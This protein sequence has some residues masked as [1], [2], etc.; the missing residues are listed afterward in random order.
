MKNL[1]S[2]APPSGWW[3]PALLCPIQHFTFYQGG[4]SFVPSYPSLPFTSSFP[5]TQIPWLYS[6]CSGPRYNRKP[7]SLQKGQY[8]RDASQKMPHRIPGNN[9]W[10]FSLT[11]RNICL[12]WTLPGSGRW[13]TTGHCKRLP[14]EITSSLPHLQ[15]KKSTTHGITSSCVA[16][17]LN[18]RVLPRQTVPG[19]LSISQQPPTRERDTIKLIRRVWNSSSTGQSCGSSKKSGPVTSGRKW[20][21]R[22]GGQHDSGGDGRARRGRRHLRR[23]LIDTCIRR[24]EDIVLPLK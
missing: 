18:Y 12:P 15:W 14:S 7:T 3:Y 23:P 22:V 1:H 19:K 24:L 16:Q 20:K 13:N 8:N 6:R 9:V 11:S 2:S 17:Q 10:C 5:S 4:A 21:H